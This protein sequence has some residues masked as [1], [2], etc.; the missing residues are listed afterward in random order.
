M[1]VETETP[2]LEK[3]FIKSSTRPFK[4]G[5]VLVFKL[6][7]S[8]YYPAWENQHCLE[9]SDKA[10]W[11]FEEKRKR[12]LN[13]LRATDGGVWEGDLYVYK[14]QTKEGSMFLAQMDLRGLYTNPR[15]TEL[16]RKKGR[17]VPDISPSLI[18]AR[19]LMPCF[20]KVRDM[21]CDGSLYGHIYTVDEDGSDWSH[22]VLQDW[23]NHPLTKEE[24][25]G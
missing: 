14:F 8:S 22:H 10:K 13:G 9:M 5:E 18:S 24:K 6:W 17:P 3:Q 2:S 21:S 1:A 15:F 12:N 7:Q 20:Q 23:D 16:C 11:W 25:M 4:K 19:A